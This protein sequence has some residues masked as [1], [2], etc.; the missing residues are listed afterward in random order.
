MKVY[1]WVYAYSCW[2][3][4][5]NPGFNTFSYSEGLTKDEITELER[6]CS[7]T[8]PPGEPYEPTA[9]QIET[10]F[11]PAF[12]SFTLASGK[13]VLAQSRYL[14]K[15]FF[16]GRWGSLIAHALILDSGDWPTHAMEYFNSEMFWKDL[17][18]DVK[19]QALRIRDG[20][21]EFVPPAP[22]PLLPEEQLRRNPAFSPENIMQYIV[23]N[24]L[25]GALSQM[26]QKLEAIPDAQRPLILATDNKRLPQLFAAYTMLYPIEL[27]ATMSFATYTAQPRLMGL[28]AGA[29]DYGFVGVLPGK[30]Q[31]NI[32]EQ[33]VSADPWVETI[34]D[35]FSSFKAYS[36]E[37]RSLTLHD[38]PCLVML[39]KVA[40]Q[41]N[42]TVN[43]TQLKECLQLLS[44]KASNATKD[45]F[46]EKLFRS[47][48]DGIPEKDF[49]QTAELLYDATQ[50][51]VPPLREQLYTLCAN[52]QWETH[53]TETALKQLAWFEEKRDGAFLD[54]LIV[55]AK[56]QKTFGDNIARLLCTVLAVCRRHSPEAFFTD[57][58]AWVRSAIQ[59]GTWNDAARE[60]VC[61]M[62]DAFSADVCLVMLY[63]VTREGSIA[64]SDAQLKDCLQ[65]LVKATS[66]TVKDEFIKKLFLLWK[67]GIPEKNFL[68]TAESLYN[69]TRDSEP[70]LEQLN[71]L[72]LNR[73][74]ETRDAE[75]ALQ[76]LDWFEKHRGE[77]FLDRFIARAKDEKTFDGNVAR[78]L[79]VMLAMCRRHSVEAFF[80]DEYAWFKSAVQTRAWDESACET[81]CRIR[82]RFPP[83]VF[84]ML[85]RF[86][87]GLAG[88]SACQK[89]LSN[90]PAKETIALSRTLIVAQELEIA[91]KVV[92]AALQVDKNKKNEA[93]FREILNGLF[94]PHPTFAT[95]YAERCFGQMDIE[96]IPVAGLEDYCKLCKT[97]QDAQERNKLIVRV[98]EFLPFPNIEK[99]YVEYHKALTRWV[100]LRRDN[101]TEPMSGRPEFFLWELAFF[102]GTGK[103]KIKDAASYVD[104][105]KNLPDGERKEVI[106]KLSPILSQQ[107]QSVQEHQ[108]SLELLES[109]SDPKRIVNVYLESFEKKKPKKL[110]DLKPGFIAL[111]EHCFTKMPDGELLKSFIEVFAH[112]LC[113]LN[114]TDLDNLKQ[115]VIAKTD[116][117]MKS[118]WDTFTALVE[119]N[120]KR[121]VFGRFFVWVKR[122]FRRR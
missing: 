28:P 118:R 89:I 4:D 10:L 1:Q 119:K 6:R 115:S 24:N 35:N 25:K 63:A 47:W 55:L 102:T 113:R 3:R 21:E 99:T 109:C 120:A 31:F 73:Q 8:C 57:D 85:L 91:W 7:Y 121:G 112:I 12:F 98:S 97:L 95:Q 2:N 122:L 22:M 103:G 34:V 43:N 88:S 107:A 41:G 58:Y 16:D 82:S 9:E 77:E 87:A 20:A 30:E 40:R 78:M 38:L 110:V 83:E 36:Q 96:K 27:A 19:Q 117:N 51:S 80:T 44:K 11:P 59:A 56:G 14:G 74:W 48:N 70:L 93:W 45:E 26:I 106:R 86:C 105:C 49:L 64:L 75:V 13:K 29:T 15:G 100:A 66:R 71:T 61:K 114:Q 54:K 116:A 101:D 84:T 62:R 17:P 104:V 79:Y 94:V 111:L 60:T 46:V 81:I 18:E 108:W 68:Q 52:R 33:A 53:H 42:F 5:R 50:D 65:L 39:Y 69:A 67:D 23:T 76:Q 72:C 90:M 32:A 37:F 92:D